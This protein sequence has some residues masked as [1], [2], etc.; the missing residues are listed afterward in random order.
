MRRIFWSL[1]IS[2]ALAM[3]AFGDAP[4]KRQRVHQKRINEGVNSG[5]L[6]KREAVKLDR[7]E[8]KLHREIRRDRADGGGLTAKERA[9][10]DRKQDNLSEKIAKE[11]HDNQKR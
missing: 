11:K 10:I 1:M 5:E 7:R 2:G 4:A 3:A 9:K 6:T 8:A